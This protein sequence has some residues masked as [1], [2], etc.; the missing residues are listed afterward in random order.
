MSKATVFAKALSEAKGIRPEP[1]R[2][3]DGKAAASVD[4]YGDLTMD[5]HYYSP[6]EA[7]RLARWIQETYGIYT[8]EERCPS[9]RYQ[10]T[11]RRTGAD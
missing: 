10:R 3:Q 5:V 7:A 1:F 6:E 4:D 11:T 8:E 9:A 2:L